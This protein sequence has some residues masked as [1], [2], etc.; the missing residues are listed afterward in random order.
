MNTNAKQ[1]SRSHI[2]YTRL[3]KSSLF[4][5]GKKLKHSSTFQQLLPKLHKTL[6]IL[7]HY[8]CL[9]THY[10][11]FALLP[12]TLVYLNDNSS[13]PVIPSFL[14]VIFIIIFFFGILYQMQDKLLYHPNM[15]ETSRI[16]V[17]TMPPNIPCEEIEISTPDNIK[18]HGFFLK[19]SEDQISNAPT[20]IYFHGNAG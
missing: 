8:F 3:G 9:T 13:S 7:G 15:P 5:V 18:L 1:F 6:V 20:L 2:S 16:Y 4:S 12:V 14:Y 11:P 10:A 17:G 19:Q